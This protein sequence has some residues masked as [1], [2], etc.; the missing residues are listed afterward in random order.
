MLDTDDVSESD[1]V[2]VVDDE[3][4]AVVAISIFILTIGHSH[5]TENGLEVGWIWLSIVHVRGVKS[6][7]KHILFIGYRAYAWPCLAECHLS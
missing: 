3:H 4:I 6:L 1:L 5:V 7:R 2:G